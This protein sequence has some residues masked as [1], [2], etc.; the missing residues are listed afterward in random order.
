MVPFSFA[1][2]CYDNHSAG[3]N[4]EAG[5]KALPK[6]KTVRSERWVLNNFVKP[7]NGTCHVRK[8]WK[9]TKTQDSFKATSSRKFFYFT[10]KQAGI[11]AKSVFRFFVSQRLHSLP[12]LWV[13]P[14]TWARQPLEIHSLNRLLFYRSV[15]KSNSAK[16]VQGTCL[17]PKLRGERHEKITW[18]SNASWCK[19]LKSFIILPMMSSLN[20]RWFIIAV[21][22][23][24]N[25]LWSIHNFR[26]NNMV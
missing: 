18:F 20:I 16:L 19:S 1:R 25:D 2:D 21:S 13:W 10:Y 26:C 23:K 14:A 3:T 6:H 24:S 12:S 9:Q 5:N 22:T 11:I 4:S 8:K 15:T 7:S 17:K